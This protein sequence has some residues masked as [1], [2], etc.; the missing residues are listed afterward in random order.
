[1]RKL[2]AS[3]AFLSVFFAAAVASAAD[4]EADP[5]NYRDLLD[6]LK[7][8]DT[9]VF[10]PG[11]YTQGLPI[12]NLNGTEAAWI[13]VRGPAS[14]A[15]AV[16]EGNACCNTVEL[17]NSSYIAVE[18]ITVDGKGIA[19][20]FGV[21]AKNGTNN[22]VHHV[23]IEGCTFVGQ[24][25]SQQTVAI[26]TKTPTYGW[27]VRRNVIDGAG[28]G[29]YFGN[30]SHADPFVGAVIEYNL[31]KRTIGYG[32]QIKNQNAWPAHAALP[33][34]DAPRTIIRHNVFLKDDQPSPD[35]PRP[36]L[37]VGGPPPSGPGAGAFAE[38]YGNVFV[39]NMSEPLVQATGRVSVHDNLF[40]DVADTAL[41]LAE[42]EGFPLLYARVYDN[43]FYAAKRAVVFGSEATEGDL[44]AG[45]LVFADEAVSGPSMGTG[46][47]LV[48][49]AANAG[50]YV[51]KPSIALG[52]MDF[53]PLPGKAETSPLDTSEFVDDPEH[54]CDF[55]G[56]PRKDFAF[57]GAYAGAG[58][59]PGWKPAEAIKPEVVCGG[60]SG[61]AGGSGGGSASGSGGGGGSAGA[62]GDGGGG[63]DAG[64]DGGCGCRWGANEPAGPLVSGLLGLLLILGRRRRCTSA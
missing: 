50:S 43:T 41:R 57:R 3:L 35:G 19:S 27:I 63:G 48:D 18:N 44:V 34:V 6:T 33:N 26:S 30:S 5:S 25:G 13:T 47:N 62:G 23:R 7:P 29:M 46:S 2:H 20:V 40:V 39:H 28:T 38:V 64:D 12:T 51:Q 9:L 54:A 53:Y 61:G 37:L 14:G 56:S 1:M 45:N 4:V 49:V 58:T 52:D 32:M 21:S 55:N 59:N 22:V 42:H 36:N 24:N 16:F 17:V 15:P 60:G 31:V 10:A 11:T 8:G